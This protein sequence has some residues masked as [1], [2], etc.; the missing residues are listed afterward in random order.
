MGQIC[1]GAGTPNLCSCTP[2]TCAAAGA[3]C[4]TISDGCGQ[5]LDCGSCAVGQTCG[6]GGTANACSGGTS[7]CGPLV[8]FDW[9]ADVYPA[10]PKMGMNMS[11][12]QCQAFCNSFGAVLCCVLEGTACFP[13]TDS[14]CLTSWQANTPYSADWASKCP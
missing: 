8:Q 11:P 1:G 14:T 12:A 2:T 10:Y 3:T 13:L 7:N 6:G 9:S 5:T 4:G